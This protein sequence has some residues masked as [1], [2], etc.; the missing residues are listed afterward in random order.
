ME[1]AIGFSHRSWLN[2]ILH[3]RSILYLHRGY[4][5]ALIGYY[6]IHD[7][8]YGDYYSL[9]EFLVFSA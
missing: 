5:M 3:R 1:G 8:T 2:G 6:E 7:A 4:R 9:Y